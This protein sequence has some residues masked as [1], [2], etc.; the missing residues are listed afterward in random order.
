[1]QENVIIMLKFLFFIFFFILSLRIY[2]RFFNTNL[3]ITFFDVGQ[4]DSALIELPKGKNILVDAGGGTI[5]S[6]MGERILLKEFSRKWI[7]TLDIGILSHPDS[8]HGFGFLG[9]FKNISV[10]EFWVGPFYSNNLTKMLNSYIK[11]KNIL[12]RRFSKKE[13]MEINGVKIKI[14]SINKLKNTNNQ[15]LILL[16]EYKGCKILFPGDIEKEAEKEV[17]K[18]LEDKITVLKVPHHGSKTSSSFSFINK[19]KPVFSVIS[20]GMNNIYGHPHFEV[21][22]NYKTL[23]TYLLRTDFH[24]FTEFTISSD[25]VISCNNYYGHCGRSRC[26]FF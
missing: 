18:E 25:G 4:G 13:E 10:K 5:N 11:N 17:L 9:V 22:R 21:S 26:R 16:L 6:N 14:F 8:D 20:V 23:G 7:L 12:L 19:L 15:S 24:G 1:L 2:E 3:K